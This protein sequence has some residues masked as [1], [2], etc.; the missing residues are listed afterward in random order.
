MAEFDIK[1]LKTSEWV[2]LIGAVLVFIGQFLAW[3]KVDLGPFGSSSV[4]GFHYFLQGTIP[5]LLAIAI[6]AVVIIRTFFT[7]VKMPD[8][9]G[10]LT[11]GQTYLI[12]AGIAAVLV[13]TRI[14]TT[15][16]PSEVVSRGAGIF[17]AFIGAVAMVVGAFLKFQAKE[18]DAA[19][20]GPGTAPPTPF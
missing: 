2:M 16:G 20:A 19:G 13:L 5:W 17:I 6:G 8:M 12:A 4:N 18:D 7:D 15:D 10:P 1:K 3:F 9:V 11:W 14:I